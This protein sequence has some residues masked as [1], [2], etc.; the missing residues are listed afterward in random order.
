MK[1]VMSEPALYA[2]LAAAAVG[3]HFKMNLVEIAD[4]LSDFSLPAGRM[5]VLPGIKHSFI[6]DD[7]YNSSPEA[8]ISAVKILGKIKIDNNAK[9]YAIM[10]DMLEIGSFTEEG[11]QLVGKKIATEQIDVLVAVGERSRDFIRGAKEAG[12]EDEQIFYFDKPEEAGRFLQNR[13]KEG[14]VLLI[15]GSQ[16]AR[17]EKVVKELIAEPEQADKLLVRQSKEWQ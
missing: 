3:L 7:T 11:H 5:N 2:S 17:M 15:K 16:G 8:A 1:N 4:S 13:I 6:I 14:D 10:G 12:L 9:K